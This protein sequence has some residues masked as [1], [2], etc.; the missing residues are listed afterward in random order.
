MALDIPGLS[1]SSSTS[2]TSGVS[3][4]S[5]TQNMGQEEFSADAAGGDQ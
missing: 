3:S 2:G 1:G 4:A 5:G